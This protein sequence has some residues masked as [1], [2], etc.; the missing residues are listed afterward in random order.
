MTARHLICLLSLFTLT[1][2]ASAQSEGK[3]NLNQRLFEAKV[4]DLAK[5]M[6]LTDQQVADFKPIYAQYSKEMRATLAKP[7]SHKHPNLTTA[8][9]AEQLKQ[10]LTRQRN[11]QE[12]RIKYVDEF[13][14]VLEPAQLFVLYMCEDHIQAKILKRR[15]VAHKHQD[16]KVAAAQK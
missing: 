4:S 7:K 8:E 2:S 1:L 3:S 11:A 5:R 16:T 13:A 10:R 6:R 14:K 9:A 15:Q 12:V